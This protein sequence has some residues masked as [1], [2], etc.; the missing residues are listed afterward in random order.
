MHL[1][2]NDLD[3]NSWIKVEK[4]LDQ[5]SEFWI[6]FR[7]KNSK[8][9]SVKTMISNSFFQKLDFQFRKSLDSWV[10]GIFNRNKKKICREWDKLSKKATFVDLGVNTC[11]P[12]SNKKC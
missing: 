8:E 10:L 12:K 1:E 3:Q 2:W 7:P 4:K 5:K 11:W 9:N 6:E